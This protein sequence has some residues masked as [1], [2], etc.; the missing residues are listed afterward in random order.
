MTGSSTLYTDVFSSI[1]SA[2]TAQTIYITNS[3]TSATTAA[4]I[5]ASFNDK[6]QT[7]PQVVIYPISKD[8]TIN[9]F[10]QADG[11]QLINVRVECYAENT[12]GVDQISQQVEEVLR[13]ANIAGIELVALGSDYAFVNPNE[14]KYHY[15]V[16]TFTYDRE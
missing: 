12:L 2:L 5:N 8:E 3:T 11:K 14:A 13:T 4:S 16:L 7:K 1:R 6:N 15:K 10:G 9:K